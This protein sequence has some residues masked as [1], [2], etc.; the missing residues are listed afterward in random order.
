MASNNLSTL[1]FLVALMYLASAAPNIIFILNDDWGWNDVG[2]HGACDFETP[3]IDELAKTGLELTNYYVQHL[4]TPTRSTIMSGR[5]PIRDGLQQAVINPASPYGMPLNL[6]ILPQ[7][8]QKVGYTTHMIG[9]WHLGFFAPEYVPTARGFDTFVGFYGGEEDY[10]SKN[11]TEN[12]YNGY[13]F[14]N[15]TRVIENY[16]YSTHIYG[17]EALRI[18]QKGVEEQSDQAFFMYIPM[19]APHAPFQAPT[20]VLDEQTLTTDNRIKLAA[21]M[22]VLDDTIGAIVD[23]LKSE[24][25]GN[26]WDNTILIVSSDNGG[27][28]D[29]EA[30]NFPLRGTK[31]TLFE[32]GVK[33]IG[34]VNGGWLN[35]DLRGTQMNALM[36][37]TDW[38]VTLQ[39]IAGT[40]PSVDYLLDSYDQTDN[41]VLGVSDSEDG[42][43][44]PREVLLHNAHEIAGAIRWRDWKLIKSSESTNE[45]FVDVGMTKKCHNKWCINAELN[46]SETA[47]TIQCSAS[48]NYNHPKTVN[49]SKYYTW[50]LF[51]IADDPCE[52]YDLKDEETEIY[53]KMLEMFEKFW[54]EQAPARFSVF[55]VDY[56]AA[57]PAEFNGA[58][59]PWMILDLDSDD[60]EDDV[61]GSTQRVFRRIST[62]DGKGEEEVLAVEETVTIR[63]QRL[64]V[65][66]HLLAP[67]IGV[68][69]VL[70][71]FMLVLL[72]AARFV[73]GDGKKECVQPE[74]GSV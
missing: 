34:I 11:F 13:D 8:L 10:F 37:S 17:A 65:L 16:E 30:S 21:A 48:G 64:N 62:D 70:G 36:H 40:E 71:V 46:E 4:C 1:S 20:S 33:A 42:K 18:L 35:D 53:E 32:G 12:G 3:R 67:S 55:P 45:T 59:S 29:Y 7:E 9:K 50:N 52:Y 19:Q 63:S 41:L 27:D 5:Y 31:G 6:T 72:V 15:G 69:L 56:I 68:L 24:E 25:S 28:V 73:K 57:D 58:W 14:R 74:Y 51:N 39:T 54:N 38:F 22:A 61:D 44:R 43:Y 2:F 66:Q 47:A 26:M 23:Y 60:D 49:I